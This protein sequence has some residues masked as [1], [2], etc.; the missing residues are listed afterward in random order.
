MPIT[1]TL[2][3]LAGSCILA[4]VLLAGLLFPLAGGFGFMSNRAADA[5][6]NVSAELVEGTVPAVSTMVDVN[7]TPFAWLYEQRRFEVPSNKIANDM[8]LAIVSIED[9]R[10]A[11]HAG[12]DWQGTF[13]AFLTNTSGGEVSQ[14]GSTLDQQYVKNYLL[15]VVAKTDAE[16]RAA[17]ETTPAR[18][19]REIRMALTLDKQLT[20][21]E[22]L[23]RYLNLVPFGNSSYGIQDAAQTYFGIDAKDLNVVQS[24]MLAGMVQSSSKLNPYTNPQGVLERRN[25]VLD[26][27]I[28]NIP[29]RADEFRRAKSEPLGVLAE[30]KGLPRGCIAAND[31]GFFCDYALQYLAN[32]GI[33]RDQI[34]KGGYLIRTTLDPAVQDSVKN[35]VVANADP[36]LDDIASVMNIVAP[37]QDS[38]PVLAM[39]SSRTYGLDGNAHQTVQPQPFSMVGDGAGSVFKIFTVAAAMEKGLGIN[40]SLDVPSTYAAKGMGNSGTPGC[41]AETYC[42]KNAGAYRSP[43]S[44]TDAL[45]TS[46]NT[47]FVKLIQAVGVTPTVDMAVRLGLRSY[48]QAG[49]SGHGNQSLADMI[50][51]QN[52]GSFT[53]GPVAINPLE[54]SNVAATIASGGKWCPPTPIKEVLD[55]NGKTVPLTQQACE[56]VVEPGLANTLAHALSKDDTSGTAAAAAQSVGWNVPLAAKTGTTESHRSSAFLAFTNSFAGAAYIYGDS[57]TPGEICSF[58]LRNCGSGNLFGGNEPARSWLGAMKNVLGN[59]PPSALPPI[60]DK[61]V[62]GANNSQIPDVVGM[63]QGEATS[64][65]VAAGFQVSIASAPGSSKGTVLSISPDGSAIPGSVITVY[66]SDGTQIAAP[67]SAPAPAPGIPGLP[68]LPSLPPIPIPIPIP[69]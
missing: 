62:R 48:T 28:Q 3:R 6:D 30:P 65:L 24:A 25:T 29:S 39:A 13:R 66:V 59:F 69:R 47:A 26:T 51:D 21:D 9:R 19:I 57:P 1:R 58:P 45:A 42:V 68:Q 23:T 2:A 5:V 61:Y 11:E 63:S 22:I 56:Q 16:R 55:R 53:L 20:K 40:A 43:M 32:A 8:K 14:G 54:L 37:G 38:H 31:R 10:F 15:L 33:S 49:T 44:V 35:A 64:T 67:P 17:I 7:G 60:D 18:K 41:P 27:M 34:N 46:P 50:K 4:A 12:V 52:L 36:N